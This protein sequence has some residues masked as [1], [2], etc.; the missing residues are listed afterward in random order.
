MSSFFFFSSKLGTGLGRFVEQYPL[1]EESFIGIDRIII[2][3]WRSLGLCYY[4]NESSQMN[5]PLFDKAMIN[6]EM[7]Y[8][9]LQFYN[10]YNGSYSFISDHNQQSTSLY[11]TSL[12]FGILISPFITVHDNIMIDRTLTWILS[13]QN[14]DGS[15]D[16]HGLCFHY[17]LCSSKYHRESLTALVLYT[18]THNHALEHIPEFVYKRLYN[19]EQSPIVRAQHY[20]ESRLDYVK[21]CLLTTT[22]IEFA[23]IQ[24]SSLS[25]ILKNKIYQNIRHRQ[26]TIVYED[27]SK[28]LRSSN[29]NLTYGDQLLLNAL[30]LSVY[31][32]YGDWKTTFD[33]ARWLVKQIQNHPHYDTVLDGIIRTQAW[34]KT[35]CLFYQTFKSENIFVMINITTDNGQMENFKINS[36]NMD[37]TQKLHLKLPVNQIIYTIKGFGIADVSIKQV[38]MEKQQKR[39]QPISYHLTNEFLPMSWLN[40]VTIRTCLTYTPTLNDQKLANNTFNRTIIVSIQI[41][42]GKIKQTII[43]QINF[44][45]LGMRHNQ[46]R[47]GFFLNRVVSEIM[48]FIFDE[49]N[50]KINFIFNVPS[51]IYGRP[52]CFNWCLERLSSV[53]SWA[54]I[55]IRAYDYLQPESQ[56]IRLIPVLIYPKLLGYS[57]VEVVHRNSIKS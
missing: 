57:F 3:L 47:I 35:V 20:L 32:N 28:F 2:R 49:R 5:S 9:S 23:L 41:P 51:N 10:D 29:E 27:D 30:T 22:L 1:E 26:L 14:D 55:Q 34:I 19:D 17:R 15:F 11:L 18:M 44:M 16:D 39:I 38:Y 45:Y 7:D 42:S 53:T 48:Y 54:P 6:I 46:R 43:I 13:H 36:S 4:L 37:I 52:I 33:I 50:S 24:D 31:A 12:V 8:Q 56:I 40:E 25:Q 21:S